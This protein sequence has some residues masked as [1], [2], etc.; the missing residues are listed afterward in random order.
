[1]P[2]SL[3]A[4]DELLNSATGQRREAQTDAQGNFVF[5]QLLHGTYE[6]TVT[7]EGFKR[8]EQKGSILT[9]TER[10]ALNRIVLGVMARKGPAGLVRS[11]CRSILSVGRLL[12]R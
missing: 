3:Q 10:A 2:P 9:S 6:L 1:V 12:D 11:C 7:A 8:Y 5:L 4:K